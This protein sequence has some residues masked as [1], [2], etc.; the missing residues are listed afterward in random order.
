MYNNPF[1]VYNKFIKKVN[2][3]GENTTYYSYIFNKRTKA[4]LEEKV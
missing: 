3:L 4:D 2:K 1:T